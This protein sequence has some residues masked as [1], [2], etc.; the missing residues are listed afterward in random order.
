MNGT[1]LKKWAYRKLVNGEKIKSS[2]GLR[3]FSEGLAEM[4]LSGDMDPMEIFFI[5]GLKS[6]RTGEILQENLY[7]ISIALKRA[8]VDERRN[9]NTMKNVVHFGHTLEKHFPS[10]VSSSPANLD[11]THTLHNM[12]TA[13]ALAAKY[14]KTPYKGGL[15]HRK[16]F[17]L[18][19]PETKGDISKLIKKILETP[20]KNKTY[21]ERE[22]YA[23]FISAKI[24]YK[25]ELNPFVNALKNTITDNTNP[26]KTTKQRLVGHTPL[27]AVSPESYLEVLKRKAERP[28]DNPAI[29]DAMVSIASESKKEAWEIA[30]N[31]IYYAVPYY[32][33]FL[34]KAL[35]LPREGEAEDEQL[36][37]EK[38]LVDTDYPI[39]MANEV[40]VAPPPPPSGV[41][42][43]RH[44]EMADALMRMGFVARFV[45]TAFKEP[46]YA[47]HIEEMKKTIS[48]AIEKYLSEYDDEKLLREE[49]DEKSLLRIYEEDPDLFFWAEGIPPREIT[50][51]PYRYLHG[52]YSSETLR[53]E[54]DS[55]NIEAMKRR[56]ESVARVSDE[57]L[58]LSHGDETVLEIEF[59][60]NN[61]FDE[62][63]LH[64][65]HLTVTRFFP[66]HNPTGE[67]TTVSALSVMGYDVMRNMDLI[68][69]KIEESKSRDESE[70]ANPRSDF[71]L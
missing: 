5:H 7:G 2:T 71:D 30:K 59:K 36:V 47:E 1:A 53:Y 65:P 56:V 68:I 14:A 69:E 31:A 43:P 37:T 33:T 46:E 28:V 67:D 39:R 38:R 10:I 12:R 40:A 51:N 24:F 18:T 32:R 23:K 11:T 64:V 41:L 62:E 26:I 13:C 50:E 27:T 60:G 61:A 21:T 42:L 19:T 55:W 15:F 45:E 35:Y 49:I 57:V 63:K 58:D 44:F 9:P 17:F 4:F 52:G 8:A 54:P 3:M 25:D 20:L 70:K 48:G 29:F 16:Y 66:G 34:V 22:A 6:K